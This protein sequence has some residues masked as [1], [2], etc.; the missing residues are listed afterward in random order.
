MKPNHFGLIT[1]SILFLTFIVLSLV[2]QSTTYL[3]IASVGPLLIVPFLPDIR[4]G[5]Y[6]KPNQAKGAVRLITMENKDKSGSDFLVI[7]FEQGFVKWDR[8]Q[9]YFNLDDVMKDVYIKPDPFAATMTVLKYD[10]SLH[11]KKKNWIGISLPQLQQRM[12][13]L[14]YTTNEI[15]RIVIQLSDVNELLQKTVSQPAAAGRSVGA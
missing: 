6:I 1:S 12:S 11:R 3:Y 9:L 14:S 2:F 10:L 4:S 15:N 7:L 13:Q 8:R 5:Q